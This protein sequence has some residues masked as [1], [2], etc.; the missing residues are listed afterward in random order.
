MSALRKIHR[1]GTFD[2][3]IVIQNYTASR[4]VSGGEILTWAT[5]KAVS[6]QITYPTT[7]ATEMYMG[8]GQEGLQQ[9]AQRMIEFRVRYIAGVNEKMRVL[10]NNV[11]YD[12]IELAEEGRRRF[13]LI[14]VQ[15][16]D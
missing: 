3:R 5:W 4:D 16:R 12:I 2:R 8:L 1:I 9:T 10:Y 14:K 11:V 6:A 15:Y 13:L 7:G